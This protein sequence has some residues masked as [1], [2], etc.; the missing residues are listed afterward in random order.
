MLRAGNLIVETRRALSS[1]D[2]N[3]EAMHSMVRF[4]YCVRS[5]NK[6]TYRLSCDSVYVLRCRIY[7]YR[8]INIGF[9]IAYSFGVG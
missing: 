7:I 9:Q 3:L 2:Q 4:V 5:L 6:W 8:P 1:M